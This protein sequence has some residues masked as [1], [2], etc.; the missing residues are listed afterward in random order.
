MNQLR[1]QTHEEYLKSI[2]DLRIKFV[3]YNNICPYPELNNLVSGFLD[4]LI[5]FTQNKAGFEILQKVSLGLG[6][7]KFAL[8]DYMSSNLFRKYSNMIALDSDQ[9]VFSKL[10]PLVR[11]IDEKTFEQMK[12][13]FESLFQDKNFIK[14]FQLFWAE[15]SDKLKSELIS[16]LYKIMTIP[17][18]SE[19]SLSYI[20]DLEDEF[21][22]ISLNIEGNEDDIVTLLTSLEEVNENV[23]FKKEV[24]ELLSISN[25]FRI[26][27][28]ISNGNNEVEESD[29]IEENQITHVSNLENTEKSK[30]FRCLEKFHE[31]LVGNYDFWEVLE[32]YP[33]LCIDL[34]EEDK[35][36]ANKIFEW[37]YDID[38]A[39]DEST[40]GQKF[41][42]PYGVISREMMSYY[43]G[44]IHLV[45]KHLDHSESS[46]VENI[47]DDI[48]KHLYEFGLLDAFKSSIQLV[49]QVIVIDK[50]FS[51]DILKR[52]V[53]MNP[54]DFE[55]NMLLLLGLLDVKPESLKKY[56]YSIN[57]ITPEVGENNKLSEEEA[58]N[59]YTTAKNLLLR[60]NNKNGNLLKYL[61]VFLHSD[62]NLLIPHNSKHEKPYAF[63]LE[64]LVTFLFDISNPDT[65]ESIKYEN[66]DGII[67]K[68]LTLISRLELVIRE[69][70]FLNNFYGA[71]FI[72]KIAS[73][74]DYTKSVKALKKNVTLLEKTG[75]VFRKLKIFPKET[76]WAFKN[77]KESYDSLW[78]LNVG[79]MK[80]G[81]LIQAILTMAVKSSGKKSQTFSPYRKP[82]ISLVDKHNGKFIALLT[83]K[84][85]LT[86]LAGFLRNNYKKKDILESKKFKRLNNNFLKFISPSSLYRSLSILLKHKNNEQIFRDVYSYLNSTKEIDTELGV[87]SEIVDLLTTV[88]TDNEL[89]FLP[90]ILPYVLDNYMVLKNTLLE[91]INVDELLVVRDALSKVNQ[92]ALDD[93]ITLMGNLVEIVKEK[94]ELNF[95][96]IVL[97]KELLDVSSDTIDSITNYAKRSP[98]TSSAFLKSLIEDEKFS[99]IEVHD[100][101]KRVYEND[102]SFEYIYGIVS[103]LSRETNGKTGIENGADELFLKHDK[104]LKRFLLEVFARFRS[105]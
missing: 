54:L 71:F 80:H 57:Y 9:L 89:D 27:D 96:K 39:F 43:H 85:T 58:F 14:T 36:I 97:N 64:Q 8:F 19:R 75:S 10:Y 90:E 13:L 61:T 23:E 20:H 103:T 68:E 79:E 3:L 34:D 5:N 4:D 88:Y 30:S 52:I 72:N 38:K 84:S 49:N 18:S 66:K 76:K 101:I 69:I 91:N 74:D 86:H 46:Y 60:D 63:S 41:S 2:F 26:F 50:R 73:S 105:Q 56:E 51:D 11:A 98:V 92:L 102:K 48:Q 81:K 7:N 6:N 15:S 55:R 31:I 21:E 44:I 65:L 29:E 17:H 93:K 53:N 37:T 35:E 78:Q 59:F 99:T 25:L 77:I 95:T 70:S 83:K 82:K 104:K 28:L 1:T 45:N 87:L 40:D 94:G 33:T 12:V 67:N 22:S 32:L 16:G 100:L 62:E 24:T 42:V 47:V